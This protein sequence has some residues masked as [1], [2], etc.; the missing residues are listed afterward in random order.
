MSYQPI[1][2][3]QQLDTSTA[4]KKLNRVWVAKTVGAPRVMAVYG[5]GNPRDRA[6]RKVPSLVNR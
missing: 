6:S 2:S 1:R 4:L 5:V 3:S